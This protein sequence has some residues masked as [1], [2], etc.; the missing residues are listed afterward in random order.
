MDDDTGNSPETWPGEAQLQKDIRHFE[1]QIARLASPHSTWEQGA[2][3]CYQVLIE[4]RRQALDEMRS[5]EL[6]DV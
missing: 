1:R 4:Q 6:S 3:K 2:L 5:G